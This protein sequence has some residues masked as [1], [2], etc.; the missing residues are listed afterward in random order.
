MK[1]PNSMRHLDD[2][3]RRLSGNTPQGFMQART[4]MANAIVASMLPD[5]V[6]KGGS[7]L[8]MRFGD[9]ETRFTTDLD[10]A[11]AL[12]PMRYAAQLDSNLRTGWEGFSG[13]VTP[14]E[15][16]SPRRGSFA[17]CNATL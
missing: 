13:R 17:I 16:A 2:A 11:T 14:R 3:I 9:A 6:V 5:G 4:V 15:P 10:T 8:K 12:D 1:K 7:A